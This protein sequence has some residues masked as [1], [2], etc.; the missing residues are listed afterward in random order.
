MLSQHL[1][2][3][4]NKSKIST[5]RINFL[6]QAAVAD[7]PAVPDARQLDDSG[8]GCGKVMVLVSSKHM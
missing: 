1:P 4:A 6:S 5:G 2:L 8:V 7:Q 3:Y